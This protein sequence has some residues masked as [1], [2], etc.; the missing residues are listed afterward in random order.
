MALDWSSKSRK[1]HYHLPKCDRGKRIR[2]KI[3]FLEKNIIFWDCTHNI[4]NFNK[5]FV[6]I[7]FLRTQ[8]QENFSAFSYHIGDF[9]SFVSGL[10]QPHPWIPTGGVSFYFILYWTMFYFSRDPI[11]FFFCLSK[12][13]F[14]T[15]ELMLLPTPPFIN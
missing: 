2:G 14:M 3:L 15:D 9:A 7:I 5:Y 12:F 6:H 13:I 11:H 4:F 8:I 10:S 1:R